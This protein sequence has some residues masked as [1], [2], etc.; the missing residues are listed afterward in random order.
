MHGRYFVLLCLGLLWIGP[1]WSASFDC[2]KA[3]T[4]LNRMICAD[5]ELSAL[6]SRV[7]DTYGARIAT[8]SVAQYAHVRERH[9][10]WRRQR[11]LFDTTVDALKD[12]YQRHLA[13]LNHPLLTLEGRYEFGSHAVAI[14]VDPAAPERVFISGS[15]QGGG[16]T[17]FGFSWV[18]PRPGDPANLRTQSA[19]A[20][21]L[22]PA[23][24]LAQGRL[25]LMPAIV[26]APPVPL[27][28]CRIDIATGNDE[29]MLS[30]TGQ[31]GAPLAGRY[32]KVAP[33]AD[34]WRTQ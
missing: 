16:L 33:G 29:L 15:V 32:V 23:V 24:A 17:R 9:A 10:G 5:A 1:I 12:D 30:T 28:A 2:N 11:G 26:G 14:D 4:K 20:G 19:E 13:W 3:R 27:E 21:E 34:G 31:C 25:S 22:R 8:L 6:D 7:W 18:T